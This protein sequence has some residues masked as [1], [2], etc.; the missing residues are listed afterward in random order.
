MNCGGFVSDW[1]RRV[2]S[3]KVCHTKF[4]EAIIAGKR[5]KYNNRG[6]AG[7]IDFENKCFY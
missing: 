6:L 1:P 7:P 4:F 2:M 3:Y 5:R